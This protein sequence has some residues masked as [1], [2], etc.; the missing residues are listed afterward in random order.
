MQSDV[1]A[2]AVIGGASLMGGRG[3][4]LNALLGVL[5]L[6]VIGNIMNLKNVLDGGYTCW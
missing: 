6:A 4:A 2:A 3:T 1:I 5:I